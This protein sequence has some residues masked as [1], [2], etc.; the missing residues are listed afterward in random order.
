MVCFYPLSMITIF[1]SYK[2]KQFFSVS[3]LN[4][5][6]NPC[7][8]FGVCLITKYLQSTKQKCV[9]ILLNPL[10][11]KSDQHQ[12]F[13]KFYQLLPTTSVGN[14]WGQQMRIQILILGFKG[15]N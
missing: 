4:R 2:L 5:F 1:F 12:I 9:N 13:N 11:P 8:N 10:S 6:L 15:L 14:K 7:A 3:L